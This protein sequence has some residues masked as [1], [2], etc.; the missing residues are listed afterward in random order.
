MVGVCRRCTHIW[1]Q[2]CIVC[3][4]QLQS[5]GRVALTLDVMSTRLTEPSCSDAVGVVIDSRLHG[6]EDMVGVQ[7]IILSP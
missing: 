3:S 7:E 5:R 4:R 2:A 1:C 6:L